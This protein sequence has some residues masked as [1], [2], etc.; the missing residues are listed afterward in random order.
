M[1]N[2]SALWPSSH[3]LHHCFAACTVGNG[4]EDGQMHC[5]Y[6]SYYS[7]TITWYELRTVCRS[8]A[9]QWFMWYRGKC[10][11]LLSFYRLFIFW[12]S[13][14]SHCQCFGWLFL[15]CSITHLSV[16][17]TLGVSA[18]FPC[19]VCVA[20]CVEEEGGLQARRTAWSYRG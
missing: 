13:L 10:K 14:S 18:S 11:K 15:S 3:C 2:D 5:E 12:L 8:G 9:A 20:M 7:V 17:L 19:C 4:K 16:T 1:W 6:H